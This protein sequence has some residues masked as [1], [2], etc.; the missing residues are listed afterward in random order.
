[1]KKNFSL[2]VGLCLFIVVLY[3]SIVQAATTIIKRPVGGRILTTGKETSALITCT[4]QYGP[5]TF[6]P[7]GGT[8]SKTAPIYFA[9]QGLSSIPKIGGYVLGLYNPLPNTTTCFVTATGTPVPASSLNPYQ[10]SR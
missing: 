7:F 2:L 9:Q 3:T 5:L 8:G 1:M 10:F 4:A 6:Q